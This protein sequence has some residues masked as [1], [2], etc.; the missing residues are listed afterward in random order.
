[1]AALW[2]EA[3]HARRESPAF[4]VRRE[5]AWRP[6]AWDEA[7]GRVERLAAGLLAAGIGRGDRVALL[8]STCP[9]W[10]V[11]DYA[12]QSIGAVPV[13]LYSTSAVADVAHVLADSGARVVIVEGAGVEQA[14]RAS[15]DRP[16][17]LMVVN[18]RGPDGVGLDELSARGAAL[19]ARD[20]DAVA[21]ARRSVAPADVSSI[22]YTSGTTGPPKG[23]V[24]THRNMRTMTE[25][26]ATIPDLL[27]PGETVL[28]FLPLAHSFARLMQNVAIEVGITIAYCPDLR[29]IPA[30]L[31]DVRPHIL[32]SIPRAYE[33]LARQVSARIEHSPPPARAAA[34]WALWV[35][36]D[37]KSVV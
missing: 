33:L 11:C 14:L 18:G 16:V 12:L 3:A 8:L 19:L 24:L 31:A 25:V 21:R 17:E 10:T 26:V 28:L 34:R 20:P 1:M 5:H 35:G 29:G 27:H 23:C 22:I 9:D 30:A 2:E 36:R 7:A 15:A 4:L 6:I 32:P 37:R 13:P